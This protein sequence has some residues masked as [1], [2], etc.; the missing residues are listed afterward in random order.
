MR[1]CAIEHFDEIR[2]EAQDKNV[3]PLIIVDGARLW[4]TG[5]SLKEAWFFGSLRFSRGAGGFALCGANQLVCQL[6]ALFGVRG[7]IKRGSGFGIWLFFGTIDYLKKVIL[8]PELDN[9]G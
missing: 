1:S 3:A 4:D 2:T 7:R 8:R 6:G 9:P 5:E